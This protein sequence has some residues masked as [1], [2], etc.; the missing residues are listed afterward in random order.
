MLLDAIELEQPPKGLKHIPQNE[1]F[2]IRSNSPCIDEL[3]TSY[4]ATK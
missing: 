4:F 2:K 1:W 3:P